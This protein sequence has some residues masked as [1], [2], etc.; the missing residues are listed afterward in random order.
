MNDL[1]PTTEQFDDSLSAWRKRRDK[2]FSSILKSG[3]GD[4]LHYE[5]D[6]VKEWMENYCKF[7]RNS[8]LPIDVYRYLE[9]MGLGNLF[10]QFD[11]AAKKVAYLERNAINRGKQ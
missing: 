9:R 3:W 6:D 1:F 5:I 2:A 7:P 4:P 10:D 8:N 11:I